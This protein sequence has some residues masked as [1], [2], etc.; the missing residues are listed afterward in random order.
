MK[1]MCC[2]V[3]WLL[4]SLCTPI[5]A[6]EIGRYASQTLRIY[7]V[8]GLV[9]GLFR[10]GRLVSAR[11]F[12]HAHLELQVRAR[13]NP[14]FD[15][16]SISKQFTAYAVLMLA[17]S[18]PVALDAPIGRYLADLPDSWSGI[19]LHRLLTHTSG[20]PDL[21]D[22]S[23]YAVCRETYSDT[24]LGKRLFAL[25]LDFQPREKW[26]YSNTNYWLLARVFTDLPAAGHEV[27][28]FGLASKSTAQTRRWLPTR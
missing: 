27:D 6:D 1:R 5:H 7:G 24:E 28:P 12:G 20:L 14:V 11:A 16:G 8:P 25:L 3:A 19:S 26:A 17:E 2:L 9:I 4:T 22:A 23:G 13:T 15:F 18:N 21:E 10:G